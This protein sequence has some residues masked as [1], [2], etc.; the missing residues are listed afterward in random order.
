MI[1]KTYSVGVVRPSIPGKP[2]MVGNQMMKFFC[3][4]LYAPLHQKLICSTPCTTNKKQ[5]LGE[6][7]GHIIKWLLCMIEYTYIYSFLPHNSYLSWEQKQL[8]TCKENG[9]SIYKLKQ[10]T[11]PS[12]WH[13]ASKTTSSA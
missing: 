13:V 2:I 8:C 5:L 12:I 4:N 9:E 7:L 6:R 1:G 3:V 10:K 11:L